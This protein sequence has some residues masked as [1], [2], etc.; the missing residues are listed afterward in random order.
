MEALS[1]TLWDVII[2]GTGLQQSLLAL[3]LSRSDKKILHV[4]QNDYYGGPEAA[5]TLQEAEAW[6][7]KVNEEPN[8]YPFEAAEIV[9]TPSSNSS[10][11][12]VK[13]GFS[14]AY[15]LSL[16]PHLLYSRARLL[17]ALV[18]SKV[19]RQLE[20]LAVGSWFVY[21]PANEQGE[22]ATSADS[23]LARVPNG[24]EDV[25]ADA[26]IPVKSKRALIR[27]LRDL[28]QPPASG[29]DNKVK[30]DD[31]DIALDK[32]FTEYLLSKYQLTPDLC[33]PLLSLALV[34][35][36]ADKVPASLVLPKI[37]RHLSSMGMFGPGFGAVIPKWG[38]DSEIAQVGCRACAVGGGVYVLN[39]GVESI[40]RRED[41]G[42]R[43]VVKLRD[44]DTV[45]AKAIVGSRWDLP[46]GSL[47]PQ[48]QQGSLS[49]VKEARSISIVS[50]PLESLFPQ[51]AEGGPVPAVA[52]VY[53]PG[54][55]PAY[56][57]VHSSDTGECPVGQW[58]LPRSHAALDPTNAHDY[59]TDMAA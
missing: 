23:S 15:S 40:E 52:V 33:A 46:E 39:H 27:F 16:A 25:F 55:H 18:S 45:R 7:K 26:S 8:S 22:D 34:S 12:K 1:E 14:R 59:L 48:S 28:M 57:L 3:A 53:V 50:S 58:G 32:P 13:L 54:E 19:F 24:R 21:R 47:P 56:L 49:C 29:D 6:V 41:D 37:K 2:S 11:E 17:S 31:E 9:R 38:G 5:F 20:F 4:D 36:A 42:A 30:T 43:F 10:N 51:T 35:E 44:G